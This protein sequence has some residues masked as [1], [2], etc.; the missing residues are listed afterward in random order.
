MS[1]SVTATD[2]VVQLLTPDAVPFPDEFS[3]FSTLCSIAIEQFVIV[4]LQARQ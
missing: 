2:A 3:A 4:N 1:L